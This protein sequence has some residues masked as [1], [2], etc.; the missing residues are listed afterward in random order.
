MGLAKDKAR[1][2]V[3]NNKEQG[4][5]RKRLSCLIGR[6]VIFWGTLIAVGC[7]FVLGWLA[8]FGNSDQPYNDIV[9]ETLARFATNKTIEVQLIY[10]VAFGGSLLC[11]LW[12]FFGAKEDP[13]ATKRDPLTEPL[14]FCVCGILVLLIGH[15][16]SYGRPH[17]LLLALLGVGLLYWL[18]RHFF[19]KELL[20]PV[21]CFAL[22]G[23]S[24]IIGGYRLYVFAGGTKNFS[25]I[26]VMA[27]TFVLIVGILLIRGN[28]YKRIGRA[29]LLAQ[30]FLPCLFLYLLQD[31]YRQGAK[32][33]IIEAPLPVK[34][35]TAVVVTVCLLEAVLKLRRQWKNPAEPDGL[36]ALG[37]CVAIVCFNRFFGSGAILPWDMYH[38]YDNAIGF[39]QIFQLG[40]IPYE[41]YDPVTGMYSV[42]LGS[43]LHF[44]GNDLFSNYFVC[45][46]VFLS[47]LDI[48]TVLILSIHEWPSRLLFSR[49][50]IGV[51]VVAVF[52]R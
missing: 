1:E 18:Y 19:G 33:F 8:L 25:I 5:F 16:V 37:S 14:G 10:A 50:Y 39:Q 36:I 3:E 42:I 52:D 23:F 13:L 15:Y 38:P 35:F 4:R 17:Q 21:L 28:R 48:I 46:N 30:L 32:L 31:K 44:F 11:L 27:A 20:L 26:Y 24:G 2:Q 6:E 7:I 34:I 47:S 49:T 29:I 41:D 22:S 40:Q 12:H 9:I 45:L 51:A 43:F